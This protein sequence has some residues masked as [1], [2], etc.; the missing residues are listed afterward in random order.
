MSYQKK[1]IDV[2]SYE[3]NID[4]NK[5][6]SSGIEFA[7]LR[8]GYGRNHID[9]TCVPYAKECAR[10]NIPYGLYWFS[11]AYNKAMALAEADNICNLIEMNGLQPLY[12]VYFDF[13]YDS[14]DF[15]KRQGV[16]VTAEL[17]CELADKFLSRVKQRGYYPGLY[18]NPDFIAKGFSGIQDKYDLWLAHWNVS[19]PKYDCGVWQTGSNSKVNGVLGSVDADISFKDYPS[20]IAPKYVNKE[21]QLTKLE[22]EMW[23]KYYSVAEEVCDGKWYTG[24]KRKEA[25]AAA[26]YDAAYVQKIVNIIA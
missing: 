2:S 6:K 9:E 24:D 17:M 13:E 19:K 7:I 20:I 15:A 22:A 21:E 4:W 26:G 14:V 5:V 8:A 18:T 10:L 3:T 25:L 1:G 11:Y 23:K 16:D 12:P